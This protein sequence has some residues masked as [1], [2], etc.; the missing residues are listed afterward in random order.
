MV[1]AISSVIDS[2]DPAEINWIL[3]QIVDPVGTLYRFSVPNSMLFR[4][5]AGAA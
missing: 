3:D 1:S 2:Q 4:K 5:Q